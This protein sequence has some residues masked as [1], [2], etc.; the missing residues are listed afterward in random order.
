M[1]EGVRPEVRLPLGG[2]AARGCE[3][4]HPAGMGNATRGC[5]VC[6]RQFRPHSAAKLVQRTCSRACRLARR[7]RLAKRRRAEAPEH[8]RC[9]ERERQ[10]KRRCQ[11]RQTGA[12]EVLE[13]P[14]VPAA[15]TISAPAE[16]SAMVALAVAVVD[17]QMPLFRASLV[18][19]FARLA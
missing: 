1:V 12:H 19:E 14:R 8:F 9:L 6:R 4:S 15:S 10:S 11:L 16:M 7:R 17:R 18:A 13:M 3:S 5:V 2:S